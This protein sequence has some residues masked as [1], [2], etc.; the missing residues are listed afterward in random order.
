MR[1]GLNVQ[2][3]ATQVYI[4]KYIDNNFFNLILNTYICIYI[5]SHPTSGVSNETIA[6]KKVI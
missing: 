4:Y 2:W 3:M 5:Y 6:V 1:A